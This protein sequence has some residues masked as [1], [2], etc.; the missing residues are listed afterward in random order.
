MARPRI[1]PDAL[2]I[3]LQSLKAI[4]GSRCTDVIAAHGIRTANIHREAAR[5]K[6]SSSRSKNWL[7]FSLKWLEEATERMVNATHKD[8]L[9]G[10]NHEPSRRQQAPSEALATRKEIPTWLENLINPVR[11]MGSRR[12][13]KSAISRYQAICAFEQHIAGLCANVIHKATYHV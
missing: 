8:H 4:N 3:E 5:P 6:N 2:K 7:K 9:R 10:L 11:L 1:A 12:Q 13:M